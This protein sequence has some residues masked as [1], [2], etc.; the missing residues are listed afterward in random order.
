MDRNVL[1]KFLRNPSVY[2]VLYLLCAKNT[3]VSLLILPFLSGSGEDQSQKY[4]DNF[5][6]IC[7]NFKDK[8]TPD[9]PYQ[10]D[11][12]QLLSLEQSLWTGLEEVRQVF[13]V[14]FHYSKLSIYQQKQIKNYS[15]Y[16]SKCVF[17]YSIYHPK[18]SNYSIYALFFLR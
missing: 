18:S 13:C 1:S 14:V 12:T 10:I 2:E 3:P 15:I 7:S 9:W 4:I 16:Q 17:Q 6:K 5:N 8:Y 11:C